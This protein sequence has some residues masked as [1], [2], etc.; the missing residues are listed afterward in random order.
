MDWNATKIGG[1]L[2]ASLSL[3]SPPAGDASHPT[4]TLKTKKE[5][6]K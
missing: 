4:T 6:K 5:R 1:K 2:P 3:V